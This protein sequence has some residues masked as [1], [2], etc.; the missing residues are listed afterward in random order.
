MDHTFL[1][2]TKTT[3]DFKNKIMATECVFSK[4]SRGSIGN[5]QEGYA[6]VSVYRLF[7]DI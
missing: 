1:L 4:I 5:N 7:F 3:K 6:I 2:I